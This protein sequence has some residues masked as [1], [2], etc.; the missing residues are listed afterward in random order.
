MMLK[1]DYIRNTSLGLF[2]RITTFQMTG[3]RSARILRDVLETC[4]HSDFTENPSVKSGGKSQSKN[5][6]LKK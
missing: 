6:W 4:C 1:T 3:L 2:G 5:N